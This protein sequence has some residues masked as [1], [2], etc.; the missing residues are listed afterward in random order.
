MA[1]MRGR[2]RAGAA[3]AFFG[4]GHW[5]FRCRGFRYS[6]DWA[7]QWNAKHSTLIPG[8]DSV[9]QACIKYFRRGMRGII[10]S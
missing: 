8:I 4:F 9:W 2:I 1:R 6:W 5:F 10:P 7:H 3:G